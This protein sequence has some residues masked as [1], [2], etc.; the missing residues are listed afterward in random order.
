MRSESRPS[1]HR[2]VRESLKS[3][4]GNRYN[5]A[6]LVALLTASTLFG[7]GALAQSPHRSASTTLAEQA[8]DALRQDA[9]PPV[10]RQPSNLGAAESIPHPNGVHQFPPLPPDPYES[11][12]RLPP[13]QEE[14]WLHGGSQLYQPE[15]DR[16]TW[17]A[18]APEPLRLPEDWQEPR[19]F[20]LFSEFL[21]AD[22]I[23]NDPIFHWPGGGYAITPELVGYGAYR[24]FGTTLEQDNQRQDTIGHQLFLELDLNLT[25]TE[26]FH[27][28]FRPGWRWSVGW[29]L[30]PIQ[31][32]GR[33]RRS[34]DR[35]TA[36]VLV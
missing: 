35:R 10:N 17:P 3:F 2:S 36:T 12:Q 34:L 27:M 11:G 15:G 7:G 5:I 24:L 4:M 31:Q 33:V 6:R 13:L 8:T 25:G 9:A 18:D 21:G 30:L 32:S 23:D 19:P 1:I 22:P 28:Q 20:T 16:L 14:L 29:L 26:R